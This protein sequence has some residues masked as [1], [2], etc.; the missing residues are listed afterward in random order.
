MTERVS[1]EALFAIS[2]IAQYTGA[3]IAVNL[4]ADATPAAVTWLRVGT[5]AV[6]VLALSARHWRGWTRADLG[7]AAL[8]GLVTA[9]M[10]LCFYL[11]IDRIALGKSVVIEFVGPIAVAAALT[12]TL[13]NGIALLLAAV[14]VV[15]LSGVEIDSEPLGLLFI[16]AA[17]A[18]W[19][20]YIVLGRVVARQ[21]RGMAGLGIGLA[22]GAVALTPLGIGGARELLSSGRLF[23]M[24]CLVGLLS[25]ALPYG[26]DQLVL[27]RIPMRRFAVL[28]ALLP[29]TAIAV[30]WLGLDQRPT[31]V[32]LLGA[33]LVIAGVAIQERD[34]E[35]VDEPGEVS[36]A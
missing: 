8:F 36:A 15:V 12:R 5:A 31:A 1:P 13:R 20:M 30:G 16:F 17:S 10:N 24:A 18:F 11:A 35:M 29:V 2:G 9:A 21:N 7:R 19:A 33:A 22:V 4:F 26:I 25:T 6:M 28:L 23:A 27:R 3:V 34:V 14:G 32:D